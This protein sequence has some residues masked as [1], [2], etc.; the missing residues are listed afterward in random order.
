MGVKVSWKIK[1]GRGHSWGSLLYPLWGMSSSLKG[2]KKS[3]A[4]DWI[5]LPL[6]SEIQTEGKKSFQISTTRNF[7]SL[8]H[9]CTMNR[10]T[11]QSK[12]INKK[13]RLVL[14]LV[15]FDSSCTDLNSRH[16]VELNCEILRM[17]YLDSRGSTEVGIGL[18]A[19]G[20]FSLS[21]SAYCQH[22]FLRFAHRSQSL[23]SQG[24]TVCPCVCLVHT[25]DGTYS[26]FGLN[27]RV[28]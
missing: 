13:L 20:G 2:Q 22:S 9:C 24:T 3:S 25:P 12:I 19:G 16:L 17:W 21:A 10:K 1:G 27:H 5:K 11:S 6:R 28:S 4:K 7:F 14:F 15:G 26:S 18:E 8:V 23:V